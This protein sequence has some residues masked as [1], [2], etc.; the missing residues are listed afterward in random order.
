[1][2]PFLVLAAFAL[3]TYWL[4][5]VFLPAVGDPFVDAALYPPPSA[6][7][8]ISDTMLFTWSQLTSNGDF[9]FGLAYAGW[10]G[11]CGAV[12]GSLTAGLLLVVPNRAV[13]LVVPTAV[14]VVE[15]VAAALSSSP[16]AGLL[17]SMV[18][19]ALRQVPI[20]TAAGP[21]LI[22]AAVTATIWLFIA[23]KRH[24]LPALR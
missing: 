19:F 5:F 8:G 6:P 15:T 3:V 14:F 2:I 23:A 22:L 7:G 16:Y 18:P 10:F 12:Y 21:T 20:L 4:A 13:A 17:Y 24:D 1:V 11:F 9:V